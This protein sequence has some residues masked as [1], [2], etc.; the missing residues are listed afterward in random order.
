MSVALF[1]KLIRLLLAVS[2]SVWMAGGCLFG[3]GNMN[4]SAAEAAPS[5]ASAAGDENCRVAQAHSCCTRPGAARQQTAQKKAK[6]TLRQTKVPFAALPPGTLTAP[7]HGMKDC[8]LLANN[9]AVTSKNSSSQPDPGL[10]PVAVLPSI[11]SLNELPRVTIASSHVP[12]RGPT[13]L[14][15]CV[16]L[17]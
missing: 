8:P 6:T 2:V 9:T 5:S 7:P 13:Y 12:N 16:F 17:I 11:E 3:C 10:T 14:H 1:I 15:C 4:V